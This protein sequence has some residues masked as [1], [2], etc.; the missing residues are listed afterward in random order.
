MDWNTIKVN[1]A[2]C[3]VVS[4]PDNTSTDMCDGCY[5]NMLNKCAKHIGVVRR[6][7][8]KCDL[9][10]TYM[11]GVFYYARG[12]FAKVEVDSQQQPEG[13]LSVEKHHM[14]FNICGECTSEI[15]NKVNQTKKSIKNKGDW[16]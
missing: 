15:V 14:D 16:S 4:I 2:M 12:V 7:Q 9:C 5:E 13:P 6:N 3:S 10:P 8:T 11:G 1:A